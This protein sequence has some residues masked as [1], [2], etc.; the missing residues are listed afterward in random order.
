MVFQLEVFAAARAGPEGD[1]VRTHTLRHLATDV[2]P[3]L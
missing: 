2:I 1:A 3:V